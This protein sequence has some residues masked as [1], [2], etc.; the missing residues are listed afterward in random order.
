[1]SLDDVEKFVKDYA[2]SLWKR[3]GIDIVEMMEA[4]SATMHETSELLDALHRQPK[5]SKGR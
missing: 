4:T 2:L 5:K 1:M 3:E